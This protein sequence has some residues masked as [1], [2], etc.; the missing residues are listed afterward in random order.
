MHDTRPRRR[1]CGLK[2]DSGFSFLTRIKNFTWTF[3]SEGQATRRE[4]R[5]GVRGARAEPGPGPSQ[6]ATRTVRTQKPFAL[7]I[8]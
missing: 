2:K 1:V 3:P 5:E 6:E 8:I 4:K 7:A